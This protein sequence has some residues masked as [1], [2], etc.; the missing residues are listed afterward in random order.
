MV[1]KYSIFHDLG[2]SLSLTFSF[3]SYD[4]TVHKI[5][6]L[7]NVFNCYLQMYLLLNCFRFANK[8]RI[9]M[10][11]SSLIHIVYF[12]EWKIFNYISEQSNIFINRLISW[13]VL[14]SFSPPFF[15]QQYE[16]IRNN[17]STLVIYIRI[18]LLSLV[19]P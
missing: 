5:K 18:F 17:R 4:N 12:L 19:I 15:K 7:T 10:Y 13:T 3:P 11:N 14:Y 2:L 1:K 9:I 8:I 6:R 16:G